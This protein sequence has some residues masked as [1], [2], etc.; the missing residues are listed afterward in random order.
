MGPAL[1][2]NYEGAGGHRRISTASVRS[3][4]LRHFIPL[5]SFTFMLSPLPSRPLP[6]ATIC[7][8]Q[9]QI[10]SAGVQLLGTCRQLRYTPSYL[11]MAIASFTFSKI[12]PWGTLARAAKD[13]RGAL[14]LC[15]PAG[16]LF[17]AWKSCLIARRFMG[18]EVYPM[19][20]AESSILEA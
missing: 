7:L 13:E 15:S 18:I 9:V 8:S 1:L 17:K 3:Y 14:L 12:R 5:L 2:F 10:H 19:L 20:T 11:R 16:N 4:H 6:S